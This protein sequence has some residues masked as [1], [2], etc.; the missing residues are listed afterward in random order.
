MDAIA[1]RSLRETYNP[2]PVSRRRRSNTPA[3]QRRSPTLDQGI[4]IVLAVG[5]VEAMRVIAGTRIYADVLGS[6]TS[7]PLVFA[8]HQLTWSV[9][10]WLAF[11]SIVWLGFRWTPNRIPWERTAALCG[12]A[13]WP[14][15]VGIVWLTCCTARSASPALAV[16]GYWIGLAA[17]TA[18]LGGQL[19]LATGAPWRQVA[20]AVLLGFIAATA[21]F[22]IGSLPAIAKEHATM[23]EATASQPPEGAEQRGHP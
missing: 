2:H 21:P 13:L 7:S 16:A 15:L 1:P 11:A 19:H 18:L 14:Y 22:W 4:V 9:A 5:V 10:R 8:A 12:T 6:S 20:L 23:A 3:I 17:T